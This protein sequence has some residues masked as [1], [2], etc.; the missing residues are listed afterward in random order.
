MKKIIISLLLIVLCGC[1]TARLA[2]E[3]QQLDSDY[4]AGKLT[5]GEYTIAS[6]NIRQE[7]FMRRQALASMM[8]TQQSQDH[9]T[10]PSIVPVKSNTYTVKR[11]SVDTYSV[12]SKDMKV[13]GA[14]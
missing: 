4:A 9:Q 8:V 2:R 13:I 12:Q 5:Y 7:K 6:Q 11:V 1:T 14:Q 3:Q 10:Q